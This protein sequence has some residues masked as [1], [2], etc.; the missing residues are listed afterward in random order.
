[1]QAYD[2]R[3]RARTVL[4]DNW[5]TAILV[6]FLFSLLRGGGSSFDIE[7]KE[8]YI[9][10]LPAQLAGIA[11]VLV[12]FIASVSAIMAL[13][14]F[15]LGGALEL[16]SAKYN[17]NLIDRREA[18]L[19]DLFSQFERFS[20]A[21]VMNLLTSLFVMLWTMLLI[22]P[23]I[24]AALSYSMA[25]YILLEDPDCSGYEAM[26]RSK[27]L[28]NGHKGELFTL[29]LSFIGWD[30]LCALTLGIG[31]LWLNPYKNAA[32]ASFYRE[33]S[34]PRGYTTVE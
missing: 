23:G 11:M 25:P 33:L 20:P 21:L 16:G 29:E 30:L 32:K 6:A 15:V 13:V 19:Q 17:L 18:T 14:H 28:M 22:I 7:I 26:K 4:A 10:E 5:G 1:M 2:H 24:I 34:Q 3:L 12:G 8:E 9:Q 27:E 31:Y